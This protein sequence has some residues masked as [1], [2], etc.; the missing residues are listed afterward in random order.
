M[1]DVYF[2]VD[3]AMP[4]FISSFEK[5]AN[6]QKANL[7][8]GL[9]IENLFQSYHPLSP[10]SHTTS[11]SENSTF[12]LLTPNRQEKVSSIWEDREVLNTS[13]SFPSCVISFM[14]QT[15]K[16][17][18]FCYLKFYLSAIP[19]WLKKHGAD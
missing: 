16:G 5:D 2:S 12:P 18:N 19:H 4:C 17:L 14:N 6:K 1:G 13:E 11:L 9:F 15:H 8:R 3:N 10:T 7:Q